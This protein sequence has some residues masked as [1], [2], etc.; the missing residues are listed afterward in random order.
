ML[1]LAFRSQLF[2]HGYMPQ[3]LDGLRISH[4]EVIYEQLEDKANPSASIA[5]RGLGEHFRIQLPA[6]VYGPNGAWDKISDAMIADPSWVEL[7]STRPW[8]DNAGQ[9]LGLV[10]AYPWLRGVGL[11]SPNT[12]RSATISDREFFDLFLGHSA[13]D[14]PG[15]F[16][17]TLR[18]AK[19][20]RS[21]SEDRHTNKTKLAEQIGLYDI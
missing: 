12:P 19:Q 2:N 9:V 10:R 18:E 8:L 14:F 3:T 4:P 13:D 15:L 21:I 7:T 17:L 5:L 16:G 11:G 6:N 20:L 1:L